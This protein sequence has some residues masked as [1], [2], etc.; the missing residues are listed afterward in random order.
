MVTATRLR[1]CGPVL[2]SAGAINGR[3]GAHGS[4]GTVADGATVG[5]TGAVTAVVDTI[6]SSGVNDHEPARALV[7]TSSLVA[8]NATGV[9]AGANSP[10]HWSYS[11]T[12]GGDPIA[13]RALVPIDA[14]TEINTQHKAH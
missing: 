4:L 11:A 14:I 7:D 2:I 5:A 12:S 6:T 1:S 9:A 13:G 3:V 10:S 8:S